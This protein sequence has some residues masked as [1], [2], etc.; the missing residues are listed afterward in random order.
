MTPEAPELLTNIRDFTALLYVIL[1]RMSSLWLELSIESDLGML[2]V[3]WSLNLA[4]CYFALFKH[5]FCDSGKQNFHIPDP[6]F[7]LFVNRAR[8]PP[9][10]ASTVHMSY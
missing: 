6:L 4:T 10:Q 1:R 7:F 8:D 2:I 9:V 5:C 3:I